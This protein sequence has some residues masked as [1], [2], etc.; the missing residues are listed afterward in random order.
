MSLLDR[1]V[2]PVV[3]AGMAVAA[4]YLATQIAP[5]YALVAMLFGV[6]SGVFILGI[7]LGAAIARR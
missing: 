2:T 4:M 3:A 5:N 1:L 6:I 7:R